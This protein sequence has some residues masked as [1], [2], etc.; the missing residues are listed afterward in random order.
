[1]P[2]TPI[3][4]SDHDAGARPVLVYG[5]PGGA[6]AFAPLEEAR[7]YA[8][9]RHG[10]GFPMTWGQFRRRFG[11]SLYE[12]MLGPLVDSATYH[13]FAEFLRD[14][15]FDDWG[16]SA[17]EAYAQLPVGD[18]GRSPTDEDIAEFDD[19]DGNSY[20]TPHAIRYWPAQLALSWFPDE[21][22]RE[23][24]DVQMSVMDGEYLELD[25]ARCIEI[26]AALE[27]LGFSCV[28]DDALMD[29]AAGY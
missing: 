28:E 11:E 9:L 14:Y 12:E 6:L 21:L 2:D 13:S 19:G 24:G 20:D 4:P 18:D 17:E 1:M 8:G 25:G 22:L 26:V 29:A 3:S 5:W 7:R 23:Y 16:C 10:D 15:D 27:G